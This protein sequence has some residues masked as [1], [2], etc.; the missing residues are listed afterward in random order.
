M[1][2]YKTGNLL[3]AKTDAIVNTVNC[4]GVMGRGIALQFKKKFPDNYKAYASACKNKS[5]ALGKMF[6]FENSTSDGPNHII[7][8]PTKQHWRNKSNIEDIERGLDDLIEVIKKKNIKSM[9]LPPLGCGLGGLDWRDVKNLIE[10]K[11]GTLEGIEIFIFEHWD[12]SEPK[13]IPIQKTLGMTSGRATLI[14]LMH[15]Y[16][17]G[18][19]SPFVSLIEVHKLMYFMQEAGEDLKLKY[20]K[21]PYGP[22]A[23]NLRHVFKIM[24]GHYISGY[25]DGG[26]RPEKIL[27]LMPD[28]HESAQS[29]LSKH[30]D[31][32]EKLER[33]IDLVDG[34]ESPSGLELLTTVHWVVKKDNAGSEQEI[35]DEVYSWNDRK[36]R[37]SSRQIG[38]AVETL[39]NKRW[40]QREL[41]VCPV[42]AEEPNFQ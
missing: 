3:N 40:I 38:I 31:T 33:V 17:G 20:S 39:K 12:K 28:A 15:A 5:V 37:F 41:V 11:L 35:I 18:L 9:S 4:V 6:V 34:F 26:D 23:E 22:Y 19:L 16:L 13:N 25:E 24:E 27:N 7:N 1:I 10:Y 21:A 32:R 29:F 2:V 42:I 14:E 36:K 8:F 30:P